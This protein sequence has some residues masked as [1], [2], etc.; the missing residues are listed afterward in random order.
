MRSAVTSGWR[1]P[2]AC[3]PVS[4]KANFDRDRKA[5]R[6]NSSDGRQRADRMSKAEVDRG[7]NHLL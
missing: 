2:K 6:E 7:E 4:G 3:P 1:T 5:A